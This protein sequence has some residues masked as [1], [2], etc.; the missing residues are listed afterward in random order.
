MARAQAQQRQ[1][2]GMGG[3]MGKKPMT[4]AE[5][6]KLKKRFALSVKGH[7]FRAGGRLRF[8]QGIDLP[9]AVMDRLT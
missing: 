9:S 7:C 2:Q 3:G 1:Q 5:Q 8:D 4:K 6:K